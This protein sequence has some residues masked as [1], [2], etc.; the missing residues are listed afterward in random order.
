M[1][2]DRR[3]GR[4]FVA[5]EFVERD[6]LCLI[7]LMAKIIVLEAGFDYARRGFRYLAICDD[8][9]ECPPHL[10]VPEYS[11]ICSGDPIQV[12]FE[13]GPFASRVQRQGDA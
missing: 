8:F 3:L 4:F 12:T 5:S 13:K 2:S 11:V 9:E 7:R 1:L 10:E 6:N